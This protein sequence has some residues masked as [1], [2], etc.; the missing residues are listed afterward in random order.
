MNALKSLKIG[1][2]AFSSLPTRVF[3]GPSQD[4][5]STTCIYNT[6]MQPAIHHFEAY[7]QLWFFPANGVATVHLCCAC[8]TSLAF[9]PSHTGPLLAASTVRGNPGGSPIR[10]V[11][12]PRD[13]TRLVPGRQVLVVQQATVSVSNVQ[14]VEC[15]KQ[16]RALGIHYLPIYVRPTATRVALVKALLDLLL[17]MNRYSRQ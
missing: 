15:A 9:T 3:P 13:R 4:D 16:R 7:Q 6:G 5:A 1:V 8:G 11:L 10:R 14:V 17:H 2:P 12:V